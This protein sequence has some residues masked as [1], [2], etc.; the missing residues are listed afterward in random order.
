MLD[1]SG[2]LLSKYDL[3]RARQDSIKQRQVMSVTLPAGKTL[4]QVPSPFFLSPHVMYVINDCSDAIVQAPRGD[5]TTWADEKKNRDYIYN[6]FFKHRPQQSDWT[7]DFPRLVHE[8]TERGLFRSLVGDNV[9]FEGL[10]YCI[11]LG[12]RILEGIYK[13]SNESTREILN[14]LLQKDVAPLVVDDAFKACL[15]IAVIVKW[16]KLEE[17]EGFTGLNTDTVR[18]IID[19]VVGIQ[20]FATNFPS[21]NPDEPV[22]EAGIPMNTLPVVNMEY[23][24]LSPQ[25]QAV[26]SDETALRMLI[27]AKSGRKIRDGKDE[28]ARRTYGLTSLMFHDQTIKTILLKAAFLPVYLITAEQAP[29]DIKNIPEDHTPMH[30]IAQHINTECLAVTKEMLMD[31]HV[32][33][34]IIAMINLLDGIN[35]AFS[36]LPARS[37]EFRQKFQK[38]GGYQMESLLI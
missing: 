28:A 6:T 29:N 21:I 1:Y 8:L 19:G 22:G 17:Q 20:N 16:M 26:F 7:N 27:R 35:A 9:E 12:G 23:G 10:W 38:D 33:G 32:V 15:G 30:E 13:S 18:G 11:A 14:Q 4:R 31:D 2:R 24:W 3:E 34:I 37:E 36:S 25:Y 5:K